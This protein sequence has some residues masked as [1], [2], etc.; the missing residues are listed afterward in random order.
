M[1]LGSIKSTAYE[2]IFAMQKVIFCN[3]KI[4]RIATDLFFT[5]QKHIDACEIR[6]IPLPVNGDRA[7]TRPHQDRT[8]TGQFVSTRNEHPNPPWR[9]GRASLVPLYELVPR[10]RPP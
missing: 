6:E 3:E 1:K 8:K 5:I 4:F 9:M 10:F 7:N 2:L